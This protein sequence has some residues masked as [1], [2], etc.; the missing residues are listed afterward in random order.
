MALISHWRQ[1]A[2]ILTHTRQ[3]AEQTARAVKQ[4]LG[5]D[6]GLIG[7]GVF[8]LR[9]VTIGIVQSLAGNDERVRAIRERFGLVLLDEAHHCPATTFMDV[10]QSF[11][12]KYRYGLT[13]TP[14]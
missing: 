6:A 14:D 10:M 5:V 8:D 7:Y 3:L 4:W 1:P 13:A 2:L 9:P 12:A 11:P